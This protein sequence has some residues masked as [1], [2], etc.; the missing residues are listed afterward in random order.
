[1]TPLTLED[2]W[3]R[4]ATHVLGAL[5]R[6]YGDFD[7]CEDACQEA[8]ATAAEEWPRTG[9]PDNPRAWL[10]R[11]ASRRLV[12]ARRSDRS[13]A[14]REQRDAVRNPSDA[15]VAP[16]AESAAG[17]GDDTLQLLVLC[18]H[19]ALTKASQV[20]L[21]LRAVG[22]LTT[23]QIAG[24]F[25]VPTATMAQRISRAKARIR[26]AGGRFEDAPVDAD[27][28][29]AVLHVL[30]LAFN[31][32]YTTSGG[33][34]LV[35]VSLTAEAIRLTRAL[36][37]QVPDDPE[38]AGLLALMLLT[39]ARA[40]A[41]IDAHGDLIALADQD[42]DSWDRHAIREGVAILERVLPGGGAG[43]FQLQASIAAIHA[44]APSRECTDWPQI[45]VL[46]RMLDRAAPSATVTLNL[47][48]AVGMAYGAAAGLAVVD[49]LLQS[50]AMCSRHRLH[51][52]RAHLL[53]MAGRTDDAREAF[54]T[55]ARLTSSTPEQR[56]LNRQVLRLTG[57]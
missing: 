53:E 30:Y 22:G 48:V 18:C 38:V 34:R 33:D 25:F 9:R 1:M 20:V 57:E 42:R 13:R 51:S 12:D 26:A 11:V 31:E 36:A 49:P 35:D 23:E 5:V 29:S 28:L 44:E 50:D 7:G 40:A 24:A 39:D 52:V 45:V 8:I 15:L 43:P 17:S 54:A 37:Q 2:V 55:A 32:G 47:G 14:Q 46:Y 19:P 16:S 3:R 10:I 41:R 6:K 21:T 4:E 56:Y 27:R